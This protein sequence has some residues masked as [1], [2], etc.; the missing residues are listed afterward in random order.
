MECGQ[1]Q[2]ACRDIKQKKRELAVALSIIQSGSWR[3]IRRI[4][5]Q[6]DT[7][8]GQEGKFLQ[9]R[10]KQKWLKSGD[11]NTKF[12]HSKATD[13]R[14]RNR[15]QKLFDSSGITHT[16][17]EE[18]QKVLL[19]YFSV[20]FQHS[21]PS[22]EQWKE[23]LDSVQHRLSKRSRYFLY[24]PFLAS[25][26]K[27]IVFYFSPT[28]AMG[29]D[30]MPTLFYQNHW[31]TVGDSVTQGCLICLNSGGNLDNVNS[32]LIILIPKVSQADH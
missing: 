20:L 24:M 9:Q 7:L 18:I 27:K 32:T 13:R 31:D 5:S 4:E 6:L 2:R 11:R 10:A 25:E 1:P 14:R 29:V 19:N 23:L 12:F 22:C 15:I 26:V 21:N 3:I 28:K 17:E 8:L 30:G 16:N